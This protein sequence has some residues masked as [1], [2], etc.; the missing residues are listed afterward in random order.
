M[1]RAGVHLGPDPC[2]LCMWSHSWCS[3]SSGQGRGSP[4]AFLHYSKTESTFPMYCWSEY[5][6]W[7]LAWVWCSF[8]SIYSKWGSNHK[9]FLP[10][11]PFSI[12]SI[13]LIEPVHPWVPSIGIGYCD[14]IDLAIPLLGVIMVSHIRV[15]VL[16]WPI[17]STWIFR[18][19]VPISFLELL[20][21]A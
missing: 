4:P 6:S 11:F 12:G 20:G 3:S 8:Q 19:I 18:F 21:K 9:N 13:H 2:W 15:I 5:W 7:Y 17:F 14:V 16:T 10:S 1:F